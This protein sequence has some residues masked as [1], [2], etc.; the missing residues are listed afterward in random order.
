MH[1]YIA[2]RNFGEEFYFG[3]WAH[4]YALVYVLTKFFFFSLVKNA[5]QED[6]VSQGGGILITRCYEIIIN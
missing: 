3:G 4:S 2:S 1:N 5:I 6:N